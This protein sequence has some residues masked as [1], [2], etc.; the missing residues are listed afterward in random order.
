R[1]TSTWSGGGPRP[2]TDPQSGRGATASMV[3]QELGRQRD[4][5]AGCTLVLA[6][7]GPGGTGDIHVSPGTALGETRQE[8]GGGDGAGLG[9]ADV[10]D[11]GEG[12]VQLLLVLVEQRQLPATVIGLAAGVQQLRY[13]RV[14]IA[15]DAGGVGTQGDHAGT[16]EG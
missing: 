9:P 12:A 16:G 14:V 3:E 11:V 15:H 1:A 5:T 7:A 8:A 4:P 2:C 13:Q 10:G 6:T